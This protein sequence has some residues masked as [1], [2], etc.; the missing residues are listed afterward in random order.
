[1]DVGP[2]DTSKH[3]TLEGRGS[4]EVKNRMEKVREVNVPNDND[5]NGICDREDSGRE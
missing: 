1:M 3:E 4:E 2:R 5:D